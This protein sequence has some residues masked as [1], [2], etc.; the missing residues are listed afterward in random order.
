[1]DLKARPARADTLHVDRS[2][3]LPT[4]DRGD[5]VLGWLTRLVVVLAVVGV[6]GFDAV[7]L[8]VGRLKAEDRAQAAAR[9]AAQSWRQ[10]EDV[11]VAYEAALATTERLE[12]AIPPASFTVGPD[13][14]VTLTVEHTATT[15][16]LEKV[17]P[18]RD[19]ATSAATATGRPPQ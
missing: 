18:L 14:A 7:A 5:I 1:V 10:D 11:Q 8:G 12:D 19:W 9:A 15:L 6:L 4:G 3:H 13:G 17:G 2:S 16:L